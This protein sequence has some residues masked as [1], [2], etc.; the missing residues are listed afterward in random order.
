M[1]KNVLKTGFAVLLLLLFSLGVMAQNGNKNVITQ[2]RD[3]AT[4]NGIK[5][6]SVFKVIFTQ[7]EPQLVK[8]ETDENLVDKISTA[9]KGDFLEIGTKGSV[10][11]P[12]KMIVHITA[13]NLESLN[14]SGASKFT[15]TNKIITP[16]LDITLN[17]ISTAIIT[18]DASNVKCKLSGVSKLDLQGT[19]DQ[20]SADIT[21]ISKFLSSKFEVKDAKIKIFNAS[22]ATVNASKSIFFDAYGTA[23]IKYMPH[24]NLQIT[25]KTDS[26]TTRIKSIGG[27]V[28]ELVNVDVNTNMPLSELDKSRNDLSNTVVDIDVN[29]DVLAE[30]NTHGD[31]TKVKVGKLNFEV[32]EGADTEVK[33]GGN[34]LIVS[35][36][37]VSFYRNS[38]INP[39]AHNKSAPRYSS[40]QSHWTGLYI[41]VSGYLTPKGRID[42][43]VHDNFMTLNMLKSTN[44][45][46]NLFEQNLKIS[47]NAGFVTGIGIDYRNYRFGHS[48]VVLQSSVDYF[49]GILDPTN[50]YKKSKLVV[51]YL[52]VPLL[53]E[54]QT[55]RFTNRHSFHIAGGV[56]SGLRIGSHSKLKFDKP[57]GGTE[58]SKD[59]NDFN[60]NPF[61]VDA[62][63]L[64][65]W[66][67][68]NL[69]GNYALIDMF[70][71]GKGPELRPFSV[72]FRIVFD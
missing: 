18:A 16:Q 61:K 57:N 55:N 60:L 2:D 63:M 59:R 31:S 48:N 8:I 64:I 46:L 69:Y 29:T 38:L 51:S 47:P 40:F 19:G 21:G 26:G 45:Q 53:F 56:S 43:A 3:I 20:L 41:G 39:L 68:I 23:N 24:D 25:K 7:G 70:K 32:I 9:V 4:F 30:V 71:M 58:K 50:N 17:G 1:K 72:G 5:V 52:T 62:T 13:K 15:T 36:G 28:T 66:G 10:N 65:G 33:L 6:A 37:G 67:S 12:S 54:L 11:N 14:M 34:K 42:P 27:D 44:I 22:S 35:E 49:D